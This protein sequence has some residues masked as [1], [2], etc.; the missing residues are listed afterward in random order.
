MEWVTGRIHQDSWLRGL[1]QRTTQAPPP[2]RACIS[3][4][5]WAGAASFPLL[6]VGAFLLLLVGAASRSPLPPPSLGGAAFLLFSFFRPSLFGWCCFSPLP[7]SSFGVVLTSPILHWSGA[8]F[9]SPP[10]GMLVLSLLSLFGGS[11]VFP[12]SCCSF[13]ISLGGVV[14]LPVHLLVVMPSPPPFC[15]GVPELRD[16]SVYPAP[17]CQP[18][19]ATTRP[20]FLCLCAHA[21][22]PS[23]PHLSDNDDDDDDDDCGDLFTWATLSAPRSQG[24]TRSWR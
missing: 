7:S 21:S 24:F 9:L 6:S 18:A 17:L 12:P 3:P 20:L 10:F 1:L 14:F 19:R 5:L 13:P 8:E 16:G 23:E 11:A 4:F 22:D 2:K 15:G